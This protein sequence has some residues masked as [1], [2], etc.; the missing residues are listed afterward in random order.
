MNTMVIGFSVDAECANRFAAAI[1]VGYADIGRHQF[2]D[3]ETRITLPPV[4]PEQLIIYQSLNDPNAKLVELLFAAKTARRNGVKNLTLVAPYLCYMRQDT[5]F[6]LG[7]AISQTIVGEWLAQHFD[8]V[9]TVDPHLHRVH[10]LADAVPVKNAIAL[11]AAATIGEFLRAQNR[12]LFLI[13]PDAES[14][15]W[16][17]VAAAAAGCEFG[18]CHKVRHADRVTTVELPE[19]SL[20]GASVVLVDDIVSSGGTLMS[21][22]RVCLAKGAVRV[23]AGVV[24]ALYGDL[25]SAE[26]ASS[27]IT[28][29][30]STDS[31][32]HP[33]NAIPLACLL[34]SGFKDFVQYPQDTRAPSR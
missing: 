3:G 13:G 4:L 32:V 33:T 31:V 27:G 1:G 6:S 34:A 2:P 26:L 25:V 14:A 28:N 29:I 16:V 22:A 24:H 30:W 17:S 9:L 20:A 12:P 7:E 21:A 23:D 18:V 8:A 10:R 19:I 11:S 15:Q 5:A